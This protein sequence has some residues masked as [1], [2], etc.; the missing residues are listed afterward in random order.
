MSHDPSYDADSSLRAVSSPPTAVPGGRA[1]ASLET[2]GQ[3]APPPPAREDGL[4]DGLS[5]RSSGFDAYWMIDWSSSNTP[6][7]GEDSLWAALLQWENG[8]A[9]LTTKNHLTR[10][11]L[12]AEIAA[13]LAGELAG[14][15]VLV[16]FDFA[17]GLPAGTASALGLATEAG[18]WRAV[19]DRLA[20]DVQDDDSNKNNRFAV[21]A[22]WN[23]AITGGFGPFF[24]CPPRLP[25]SITK[26]LSTTQK[27]VF[28]YPVAAKAGGNLA[29][30]RRVDDLAGSATPWFV[31]GGA[32][33]VGGQTLVG[34][35][36]VAQLRKMVSDSAVW[37]FEADAEKARVV[38][39]EIYPSLFYTR[40]R[41]RGPAR[42]H[43]REQVA[44][45]AVALAGL[46]ANGELTA[47]FAAP[48]AEARVE[49]GWILGVR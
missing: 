19:W 10:A 47:L 39:A 2:D 4:V 24:G 13:T 42:I 3:E 15:R 36:R 30:T 22:A 37:P 49:E 27:G 6:K 32:N 9:R 40:V 18:A 26:T 25:A 20:A 45:T 23:A 31:Y 17:L 33:S 44:E 21:A 38:F 14:Q 35:P 34:I 46:D 12:T 11:A 1:D 16:G 41:G 48:T 7:K 5:K 43:D 8:V 29:R 28:E